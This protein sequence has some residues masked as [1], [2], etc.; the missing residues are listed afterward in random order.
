MGLGVSLNWHLCVCVYLGVSAAVAG[1]DFVCLRRT[2]GDF[3]GLSAMDCVSVCGCIVKHEHECVC[4]RES[5]VCKR[6][7]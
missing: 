2:M 1:C 4:A 5:F 6:V 7:I 3:M